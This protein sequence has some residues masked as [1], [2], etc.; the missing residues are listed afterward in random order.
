MVGVIVPAS[1]LELGMTQPEREEAL[2]TSKLAND[3]AARGSQ[4]IFM[5]H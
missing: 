3:R 5:S 2:E 1:V 4:R